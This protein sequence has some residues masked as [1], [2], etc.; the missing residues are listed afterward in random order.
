MERF[1]SRDL[2]RSLLVAGAAGSLPTGVL[3]ADMAVDDPLALAWA[4]PFLGA[5]GAGVLAVR[6]RM[7]HVAARRFLLLG[8]VGTWWIGASVGLALA[9]DEYGE[10]WWLGPGN[11]SVQILGLE[12]GTALVALLAVFPDGSYR[13]R[14]ER[15][16]V[17][18]LGGLGVGVPV[19]LLVVEPAV[20]P[21]S[22][23]AW[24]DP[25]PDFPVIESILH[26]GAIDAL[27]VL[28]GAYLEVSL[29]LAP[30]LGAI[31]LG[32][33]YR[34]LPA[35][36]RL[37]LR[38]PMYG[39]LA[40]VVAPLSALLYQAG[41]IPLAVRDAVIIVGLAVPPASIAVGLV[42]PDLFDVDRAV[43]R[44]LLY[45][46]IW[47]ALAGAYIGIAAALG[48]A[49][50]SLGLQVAVGVT[51]VATL[52][53]APA[54][55]YLAGRAARWAY[56]RAISREELLRRLGQTLAHTLD[57]E[58]LTAEI[59]ST[60]R[61]GLGLRWAV[62]VLAGRDTD[63]GA[64]PESEAT[65]VE[66]LT[67]A[68]ERLG[69]I[70]CGR[71]VRGRPRAEDRE[72]LKTLAAQA[73]LAVHNARLANELAVS[74]KEIQEQAAEL[75]TSR[76][77][78]VTAHETARRQIERDLHDGAQQDLVALIAKIGLA[79]NQLGRDS[80]QLET[81]MSDLQ[82]EARLALDNLRRLAAGIHPVVLSDHGMVEA[83]EGRVARLPLGVTVECDPALRDRRFDDAVEGAAFYF[84]GEG[85]ANALKH[86]DARRARVE[87]TS[88][89]GQLEIAVADDGRGFDVST[90]YG[91][92]LRGLT[93]R[94]E[95][96]GGAVVVDSC[97]GR[98]TRLS[99]SLPIAEAPW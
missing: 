59:A 39:A 69:E 9:F 80:D 4:M 34:Q 45:L 62:V 93:D 37:Q 33:R 50:S 13:R 84:V 10:R 79:R 17:R 86:S 52:L 21:A 46:P 66:P 58:E 49:A 71:R 73:A 72:L 60:A 6:R 7:D 43:R 44:S 16:L 47:V 87:I 91:S 95:A 63:V 15:A 18:L 82:D 92:G 57:L 40:V 74:L 11:V 94:I 24:D 54:R 90:A 56:G 1:P 3:F 99:A 98:G 65:L 67:Y 48:L 25:S 77:R 70:R 38:W 14:Y 83:I 5:Y 32:L 61:D 26:V 89:N 19:A 96:L 78:I 88:S 51:I 64:P 36:A 2:T 76:S 30:L 53:F 41:A 97:P 28:L 42:K 29:P 12:M 22:V 27:G 75:V 85:L 31:L 23:F 68:G 8:T 35:P 55:R 81:T 20:R